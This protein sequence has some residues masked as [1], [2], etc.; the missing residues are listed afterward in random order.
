MRKSSLGLLLSILAC[1]PLHL[2]SA[3]A[4]KAKPEPVQA[5]PKVEQGEVVEPTVRI[6]ETEAEVITE[7]IFAGTTEII[8]VTPKAGGRSYYLVDSDGNGRFESLGPDLG[9]DFKIPEWILLEW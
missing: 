9:E 6:R 4:P 3:E 1:L 5:P 8:K 2:Q 7:F